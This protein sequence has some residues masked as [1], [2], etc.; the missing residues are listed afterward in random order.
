MKDSIVKFS[1]DEAFYV[2]D[3]EC[4]VYYQTAQGPDG[5]YVTT[6]VE[7]PHYIGDMTTDDGPYASED[8][9]N[10]AGLGAAQEWCWTNDVSFDE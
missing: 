1:V 6:V 5:W 3:G 7:F 8:A 4:G 10:G 9:A 2:G